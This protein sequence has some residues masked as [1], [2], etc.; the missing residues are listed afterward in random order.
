MFHA[1]KRDVLF[2]RPLVCFFFHFLMKS[3]E[4]VARW[5]RRGGEGG[6]QVPVVDAGFKNESTT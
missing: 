5:G 1:I 6:K 4:D 3:K 2:I